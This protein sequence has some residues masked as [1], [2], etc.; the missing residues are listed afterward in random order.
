MILMGCNGSFKPLVMTFAV[1]ELEHG[2]IEIV[3]LSMKQYLKMVMFHIFSLKFNFLGTI[4]LRLLFF[5]HKQSFFLNLIIIL[6]CSQLS[7]VEVAFFYVLS[8]VNVKK[9]VK[10]KFKVQ[11]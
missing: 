3:D 5:F 7:A 9:K 10:T 1:C 11:P 2:H 4:D 6:S 8:E